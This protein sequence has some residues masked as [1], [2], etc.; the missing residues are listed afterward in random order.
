MHGETR[1]TV[2]RVRVSW[3]RTLSPAHL[4]QVR[5]IPEAL[6]RPQLDREELSKTHESLF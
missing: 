2:E 1:K 6:F 5:R 3:R 4:A